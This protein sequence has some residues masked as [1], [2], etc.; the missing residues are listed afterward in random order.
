MKS[1]LSILLLLFLASST[2]FAQSKED[3]DKAVEL[4][5]QAIDLVDKGRYEEGILLLKKAS[6][7]DP[8]NSTYPYEI[9]YALYY[10]EKYEEANKVLK[11]LIKKKDA[12]ASYYQLLGNTYDLI[13]APGLALDTYKDGIEKF[14]KAGSLYLEQGV[15]YLNQKLYSKALEVFERGVAAQPTYSSNYYWL[16]S[17]YD[18]SDFSIYSAMYGEIFLNLERNSKR[19]RKISELL[20]GVYESA[21]VFSDTSV[22][23]S[24]TKENIITQ[25][26]L[27]LMAEGKMPFP[28]QFDMSMAVG[29]ALNRSQFDLQYIN[30]MRSTFVKMWYDG[31]HDKTHPN[32]LITLWKTMV[33]KGHFEAYNYWAF[34]VGNPDEY[35]LWV[36]EHEAQYDAFIEYFTENPI[37]ISSNNYFSAFKL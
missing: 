12:T 5:R 4:G 14:P 21:V 27:K 10:Q 1:K 30:R 15:I 2:L 6:Q 8:K 9:A 33:D 37:D 13:G 29:V 23:V 3:K 11:P 17:L 7:L 20:Y 36:S 32:P 35:E 24:F 25:E 34:Q 22:S 18:G 26:D 31:G 16:A 19:T 28:M